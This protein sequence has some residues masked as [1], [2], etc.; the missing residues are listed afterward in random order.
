M[1]KT[2]AAL[3]LALLALLAAAPA[4]GDSEGVVV[5]RSCNI[6]QSGQYYLAY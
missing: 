4:L 2:A 5:Q 3:V 6:V 1:K